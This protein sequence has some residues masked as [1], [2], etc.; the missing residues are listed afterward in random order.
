MITDT[1]IRTAIIVTQYTCTI[2]MVS[3]YNFR[4]M[5]FLCF[6]FHVRFCVKVKLAVPLLCVRALP[7]KAILE[8]TCTV[9]WDVKPF[10]V[11]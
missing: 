6:M 2:V 7:G 11:T 3:L 9:G 1:I 5:S 8:M 10:S 4:F